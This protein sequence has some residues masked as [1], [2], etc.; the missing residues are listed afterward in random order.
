MDYVKLANLLYPEVDKDINYYFSKYPNR[1]LS[2]GAEV[3]RFAPSPTGYLHFGGLFQAVINYFVAKNT[4]GVFYLRLEDTD[5]KRQILDAGTALYYALTSFNIL[6]DEGYK[7]DNVPQV[8][9][10]GPYV[11]SDRV[12]I[13]KCFAKHLVSI[14]R[15]FPCFCDKAESKD[16]VLKRRSEELDEQETITEHDAC[17]DLTFDQIQTNIKAGKKWAL[18]L[19]SNGDPNKSFEFTDEIKGTREIRQNGKDIVIMKNN[20]IPPYAFAHLVDDTLMHTTTVVRGEEWYQSVAAHVELFEAFGLKHPKYAHTPVICKLDNGNKRKLSK[21]KDMEADARYFM[22]K[23]YPV[24]AVIEYLVNLV[25]SDFEDWRR[26]NPD[27]PVWDFDLKLSK[28]G[29]NNPM[30]D[31]DKLNDYAKSFIAKLPAEELYDRVLAWANAYD[32]PFA[33]YMKLNKQFVVDTL[34][35]DRPVPKP[36]KDLI[37]YSMV[38]EY[39]NYMF[40]S[41]D[42]LEY[43]FSIFPKY[44]KELLCKIINNYARDFDANKDKT[45][46]F[47][48]IKT[49]A[50][51]LGFCTDN[52]EYKANP[53]KYLGNTADICAVIRYAFTSKQNTPDLYSIC[54]VLGRDELIYR[55]KYLQSII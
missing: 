4:H 50:S 23:G 15:A 27:T 46:W 3:T 34:N 40:N 30:F 42:N 17:R 31:F 10:Y 1:E 8:G 47:E 11:Q 32:K 13:Y 37:Y 52:K 2:A 19:K 7:G 51:E 16:D 54:T 24:E 33:D 20:G 18:R 6:P 21:R 35:I 41:V 12:D 43:D 36:R 26:A 48:S 45:E 28:M 53:D 9:K 49:L 44:D 39:F 25:N 29:T 22:E 38:K 5:Q 55:A 14:G